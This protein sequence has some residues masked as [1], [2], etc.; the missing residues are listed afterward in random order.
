[1]QGRDDASEEEVRFRVWKS[2]WPHYIRVYGI[3]F[4][5]GTLGDTISLREL[6]GSLGAQSFASTAANARARRGNLN[7]RSA[8][9]RAASVRLSSEAARWL[10]SKFDAKL[11]THGS[12][13]SKQLAELDRPESAHWISPEGRAFLEFLVQRIEQ[14]AIGT[15]PIPLLP[16]YLE[17]A[18][19]LGLANRSW[20]GL[21]MRLRTHGL[22]DLNDC[23]RRYRF[24]AIAGFIV[25]AR[26]HRPGGEF[27]MQHG[28]SPEDESWWLDQIRQAREF[29]WRALMRSPS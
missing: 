10:A 12:I 9:R 17:T 8:L 22:D 18:Q 21:T 11:A 23:T 14:G 28:K 15:G 19:A 13:S 27:F 3:E 2:E 5:D 20:P 16:N 1:M 26:S 25:N 29:D 24:P 6:M 4:I 7:P